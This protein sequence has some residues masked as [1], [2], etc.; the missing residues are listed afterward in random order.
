[1]G[2]TFRYTLHADI[3]ATDIA[4]LF[5]AMDG[6]TLA[7]CDLL[8]DAVVR[9]QIA[10]GVLSIGPVETIDVFW[11]NIDIAINPIR[12]GSGLKIKNVEALAYGLPLL[13]TPIGAEGLEAASPLGLVRRLSTRMKRWNAWCLLSKPYQKNS[14]KQ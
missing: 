11:P 6:E 7:L 3:P 1:M 10:D 9:Q 2:S 5:D 8:G 4:V 12:F 13:T 14:L